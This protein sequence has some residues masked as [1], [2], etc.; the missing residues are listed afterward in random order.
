MSHKPGISEGRPEF[1]SFACSGSCHSTPCSLTCLS[2]AEYLAIDATG[3]VRML[4]SGSNAALSDLEEQASLFMN[5]YG[6]MLSQRVKAMKAAAALIRSYIAHGNSSQQLYHELHHIVHNEKDSITEWL[7]DAPGNLAQKLFCN[8]IERIL[9]VSL[10]LNR[11]RPRERNPARPR[12]HPVG[13]R[14][15]CLDSIALI[16]RIPTCVWLSQLEVEFVHFCKR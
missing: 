11:D 8:A 3:S 4:E 2:P 7:A 16:Y 15:A 14:L 10:S 6:Q 1:L 13:K 12:Y 5:S 9:E